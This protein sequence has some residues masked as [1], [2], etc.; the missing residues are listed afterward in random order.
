MRQ[1]NRKLMLFLKSC[2]CFLHK[3]IWFQEN[4]KER[5]FKKFTFS[6]AFLKCLLKRSLQESI[7]EINNIKN[8]SKPQLEEQLQVSLVL[9]SKCILDLF[10]ERT[11]LPRV[12]WLRQLRPP[13]S[14][15]GA[16]LTRPSHCPSWMLCRPLG[17]SF[18]Y[19]A[20]LA[21]N[22]AIT[23]PWKATN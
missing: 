13:S 5:D 21:N 19:G 7:K 8:E 12:W 6:H 3:A 4:K 10:L 17:L 20:W 2:F 16:A 11:A 1:N 23:R 22:P 9:S 15:A 18:F 14:W